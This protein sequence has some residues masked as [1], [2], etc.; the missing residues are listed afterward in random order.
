ML[1]LEEALA[2]ILAGLPAPQS[3]TISLNDAQGRVLLQPVCSEIDLPP[4]DNSAMDGYA[5]HADDLRAAKPDLPARLR[6]V[7][8]VPAGGTSQGPILSGECLRL[9]TGSP[10]PPGADAVVMQE[11]T[12]VEPDKPDQVLVVDSVR[13]W[14][15][16]RLRAEDIRAGTTLVRGGET[17]KPGHLGLLA[18]AGVARVTVARQPIVGII[19]TGSELKEPGEGLL[20]GQIYESNR[21]GLAALLKLAGAKPVIYPIVPDVLQATE[22]ALALAFSQCDLVLTAGGASVGELDLVKPAF[23][24]LGGELHF[25]KIAIRPGRPF[26]FGAWNGKFLFGLPGNPVSAVVTLLLLMWPAIRR[27]QGALQ[28]ELPALSGILREPLVNRGERRHF[29]RVIW[30][31]TGEVRPAGAQESHVLSCLAASRGLVDVPPQTSLAAGT[32]VLI[33]VWEV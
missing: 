24:R 7:G 26:L 2:R 9:F 29:M 28:V 11:D 23:S 25:W 3:Q 10:L 16:V 32:N 18:A 19:A 30:D 1:Q 6:L 20:P 22:Q 12:R 15:N 4:F 14:E 21:V 33:R 27:W 17:L 13:P 31:S 5:V 8:R